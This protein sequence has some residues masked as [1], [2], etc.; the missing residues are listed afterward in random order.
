MVADMVT[1]LGVST[2]DADRPRKTRVFF[3][4]PEFDDLHQR[5]RS[6]AALRHVLPKILK[7]AGFTD[8]EF[9]AHRA[10]WSQYAGCS[11]PC[12]PGFILPHVAAFDV[13]ADI[14]VKA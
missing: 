7:Q 13:H 2:T 11:C 10:R 5:K 3:N 8:A 9:L 14:T 1:V 12:S 4:A 6:I